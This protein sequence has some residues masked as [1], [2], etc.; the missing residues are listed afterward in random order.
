M[1]TSNQARITRCDVLALA[2][3]CV[4]NMYTHTGMQSH[5][6]IDVHTHTYCVSACVC[7]C[8]RVCV[9]VCV[10]VC[11]YIKENQSET[12]L[13]KTQKAVITE[14]YSQPSSSV[15]ITQSQGTQ[16]EVVKLARQQCQ[17][18]TRPVS[19]EQV[20]SGH[21]RL[22]YCLEPWNVTAYWTQLPDTK[23]Q[24]SCLE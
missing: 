8:V 2:S 12:N 11:I 22:F 19:T 7:V 5:M 21:C 16:S 17:G 3:S 18:H 23:Y 9:C 1:N 13:I 15:P 4:I 24:S 14:Y 20:L 6:Y 10:C